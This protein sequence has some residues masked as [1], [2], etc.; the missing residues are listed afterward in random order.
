LSD[1]KNN[2]NPNNVKVGDRI[3]LIH[4]HDI[5]ADVKEGDTGTVFELTTIPKGVQINELDLVIWIKWD[6]KKSRIALTEGIDQYE[7]I[8]KVR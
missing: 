1:I 4:T 6:N 7:I 8:E 3:R 2:I 5:H